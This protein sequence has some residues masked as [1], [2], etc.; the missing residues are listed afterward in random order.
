MAGLKTYLHF[1]SNSSFSVA[2]SIT[3]PSR[4][5]SASTIGCL[6][7][8]GATTPNPP[9]WG[10]ANK[11]SRHSDDPP[12]RRGEGVFLSDDADRIEWK[13]DTRK[14]PRTHTDSTLSRTKLRGGTVTFSPSRRGTG[15]R[16]DGR[17]PP[18]RR[19][20]VLRSPAAVLGRTPSPPIATLPSNQS[21]HL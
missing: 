6:A 10:H 4:A 9:T 16:E 14:S 17:N 12:H 5:V 19:V 13:I 11:T 21:L 15:G 3:G 1:R 8:R 18:D 2:V 20:Y 7:G